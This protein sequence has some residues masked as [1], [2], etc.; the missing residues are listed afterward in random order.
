MSLLL[1][2]TGNV[3][4]GTLGLARESVVVL[5]LLLALL[6]LAS[7]HCLLGTFRYG[8]GGVAGEMLVF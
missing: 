2:G 5:D 4:L 6:L 3:V 1:S 7:S 8:L